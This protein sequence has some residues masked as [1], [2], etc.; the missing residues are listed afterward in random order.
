M[1]PLIGRDEKNITAINTVRVKLDR[2]DWISLVLLYEV[3]LSAVYK[4]QLSFFGDIFG[5]S[6]IWYLLRNNYDIRYNGK[7]TFTVKTE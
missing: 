6:I 2:L 1:S 3:D 4:V 7:N 5:I